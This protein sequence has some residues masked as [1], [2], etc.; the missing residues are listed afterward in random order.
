[1]HRLP[2]PS[3]GARPVAPVAKAKAKLPPPSKSLAAKAA[4]APAAAKAPAVGPRATHPPKAAPMTIAHARAAGTVKATAL[5]TAASKTKPPMPTPPK[6]K[7]ASMAGYD[8]RLVG[9]P[10]PKEPPVLALVPSGPEPKPSGVSW[11][12]KCSVAAV[13]AHLNSLHHT[14]LRWSDGFVVGDIPLGRPAKAPAAVP[15][16]GGKTSLHGQSRRRTVEK[17][18]SSYH[19]IAY[20][21]ATWRDIAN[22]FLCFLQ[23]TARAALCKDT[24]LQEWLA[25]MAPEHMT[26]VM[27]SQCSREELMC[28]IFLGCGLQ[29]TS[30][31]PSMLRCTLP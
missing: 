21:S 5:M 3:S 2:K 16:K 19:N 7:A 29:P 12:P 9:P 13:E 22:D 15:P 8:P 18:S 20:L 25:S 23:H 1:M 6:N 27:L 31:L 28:L 26:Q 30:R 10:P 4:A 24:A 14:E 11:D 17:Y